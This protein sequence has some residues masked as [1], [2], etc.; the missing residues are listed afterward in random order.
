MR[1]GLEDHYTRASYR[2]YKEAKRLFS[3]Q[4]K[5]DAMNYEQEQLHKVATDMDM[6]SRMFWC[7][8][9]RNK[10]RQDNYHVIETGGKTYVQPTEQAKMWQNHFQNLLNETQDEHGQYDNAWKTYI[11]H[12][13]AHIQLNSKADRAPEG[14]HM[15]P[16]TCDELFNKLSSLPCGKAPGIDLL[17]YEHIKHGGDMLIRCITVL[18]NSIIKSTHVPDE[19]KQG[20]LIPLYKGGRKPRNNKNSYRGITLLPVMNK[21]LERCIYDRMNV[22]L[23]TMKFPSN[24]QFAGKSGS[25]SLL[26]SFSVQEM[27]FNVTGKHGKVYAAFLDI[28]KCFDK[29]WWNGLFYKLYELG[30]TDQL[31]LLIR[32]WYIGST[33]VVLTNGMCSDKFSISRS[34]RQG[35]VLSMLMMT[36]AFYDIHTSIDPDYDYGL[37]HGNTYLGTPAFADDIVALSYTRNGLQSMLN[38]AHTYATKWRFTFSIEKSKSIVFGETKQEN[39]KNVHNRTFIFNRRPL[40]EVQMITHVGVELCAFSS[41]THRTQCVCDKA[42]GII[43][44]LTT[45]GVRPNG[46]SPIVSNMLWNKIG[47]PSLLYG[48]EVWHHMNITELVK[49]EKSQIRK[50]K[51]LQGLPMRTHDYVVRALVKQPSM[52]SM[53]HSRKL[54]FLHKLITTKGIA[55]TIFINC[56]YSGILKEQTIGFIGDIVQILGKY[57]LQSYLRR[58]A[59]GGEFPPK[60]QWKAIVKDRVMNYEKH[61]CREILQR[62]NDVKR[63]LRI[64]GDR[65][66]D[67]SF[68]YYIAGMKTRE[69]RCLI[70]LA[71]LVCLPTS[72]TPWKCELCQA[73]YCDVAEHVIMH[74]SSLAKARDC[75]WDDLVNFLRVEDFVDLWGKPDED[76][77]DVL[78]GGKWRPL[79]NNDIRHEFYNIIC[80]YADEFFLAVQRNVKWLR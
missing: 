63:F 68:P 67:K 47:I 46:L 54:N 43:A 52:E 76:I 21:L 13:V 55:H 48:S 11:D 29:I 8:I 17:T 18:F 9:H 14:V 72:Y 15:N 4:Y 33:C 60:T 36:I 51:L 26:A 57:D 30:M 50:M 42:H 56:L 73:E 23:Q 53:I 32:N 74:C 58:Y 71:K 41:S 27:I 1:A 75:M 25:N 12:K 39:C 78:L 34:I 19:F 5:Q 28:E 59:Q 65:L 64:M 70:K 79:K 61:K 7:Y 16:F 69:H 38:N 22:K 40:E 2:Q 44:S 6:D 3:K 20:L 77:L 24:L 49:L 62:K 66:Y 45:A 80:R 31:W 37:A 35:G 10:H